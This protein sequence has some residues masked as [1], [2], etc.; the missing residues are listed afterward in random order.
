MVAARPTPGASIMVT[1]MVSMSLSDQLY[2]TIGWHP[3]EAGSYSQEVEDMIVSHV[4]NPKVVSL[5]E[6]VLYYYLI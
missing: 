1:R 3:T 4:D 2:S 5:G 6:I